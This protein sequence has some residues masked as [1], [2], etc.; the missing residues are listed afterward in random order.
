MKKLSLLVLVTLSASL[1]FLSS[2][3]KDEP[4]DSGSQ[5]NTS[6][7]KV[8]EIDMTLLGENGKT[9][10]TYNAA[11]QITETQTK[12]NADVSGSLYTYN[13]A[14]QVTKIESYEDAS[15]SIN[16]KTEYTYGPNGVMEEKIFADDNGIPTHSETRK[17]EYANGVISKVNNYIITNGNESLYD[18][19]LYTYNTSG[20]VSMIVSYED[21]GNGN[22]NAYYRDSYTY[23][24]QVANKGL[25]GFFE[26]DPNFPAKHYYTNN[27]SESYNT[28]DNVWESDGDL[29]YVYV[30]DSKGNPT[31][32]TI[33][34]GL[35]VANL[36]WDCN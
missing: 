14:G 33:G 24:T 32:V 6:T 17:Y 5:P 19:E 21:D 11:G 16:N 8:M 20:D 30:F 34:G 10:F 2:C 35:A 18:Y 7:C 26:E 27:K 3:K 36:T 28:V 29:D 22:W 9:T 25:L 12:Q 4:T 13:S 23:G 1:T 15:K 31:K